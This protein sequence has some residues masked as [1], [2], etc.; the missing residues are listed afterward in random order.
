MKPVYLTPFLIMF[1]VGQGLAAGYMKLPNIKGESQHAQS[2]HE[3]EIDVH[4]ITW[5]NRARP[6][7]PVGKVSLNP[8]PEPLKSAASRK[9][10]TATDLKGFNPQPEPPPQEAGILQRQ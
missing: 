7:K 6:V 1:W 4:D 9:P 5:K 10:V 2:G 3:E 8:Q